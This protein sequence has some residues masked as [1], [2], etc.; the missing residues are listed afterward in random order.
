MNSAI[1]DILK[2]A[3]IVKG[4]PG[5]MMVSPSSDGSVSI[6]ML[7]GKTLNASA[8]EW[9]DFLNQCQRE[10]KEN[11]GNVFLRKPQSLK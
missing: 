8:R 9:N 3:V 2:I 6:A 11:V 1:D 4:L 7:G 10:A 5:A